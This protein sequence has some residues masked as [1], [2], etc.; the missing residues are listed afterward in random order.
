VE[1]QGASHFRV[2]KCAIN[3]PVRRIVGRAAEQ[4]EA[5]IWAGGDGT[6][7]LAGLGGEAAGDRP[8]DFLD[9]VDAGEV[10]SALTGEHLN[11][12]G[13]IAPGDPVSKIPIYRRDDRVTLPAGA[14]SIHV[15]RRRPHRKDSG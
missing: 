12:R 8:G 13:V 5:E 14:G 15:P 6:R 10:P 4:A 3:M 9:A 1:F 2:A 11:P 7:P